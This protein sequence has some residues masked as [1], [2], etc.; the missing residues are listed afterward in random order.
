MRN[1][2]IDWEADMGRKRFG[3]FAFNVAC[4]L[5]QIVEI[6]NS[7]ILQHNC[8][9]SWLNRWFSFEAM[10][11]SGRKWNCKQEYTPSEDAWQLDCALEYSKP[12]HMK[13]QQSSIVPTRWMDNNWKQFLEHALSNDATCK[14]ADWKGYYVKH[15]CNHS[16]SIWSMIVS[17]TG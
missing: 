5:Q 16:R 13:N 6:F 11:G 17:W 3:M 12:I 2:A 10:R 8:C 14:Q 9:A 15:N 4:G 1:P 7:Y